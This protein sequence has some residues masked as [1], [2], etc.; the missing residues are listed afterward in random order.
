[1][2]KPVMKQGHRAYAVACAASSK[3]STLHRHIRTCSAHT[4]RKLVHS[5]DACL[6]MPPPPCPTLPT[7]P[8]PSGSSGR[9][10]LPH[11]LGQP[12]PWLSKHVAPRHTGHHCSLHLLLHCNG[13]RGWLTTAKRQ[14][15]QGI[16]TTPLPTPLPP[17]HPSKYSILS[18]DA[19]PSHAQSH[20]LSTRACIA[21]H[22]KARNRVS[23]RRA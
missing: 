20:A 12:A 15:M 23:D 21:C 4:K 2:M 19:H 7:S 8:L 13:T 14:C 22:A 18:F 1:M 9:S 10:L 6:M 3:I 17:G 5:L 11:R 16:E